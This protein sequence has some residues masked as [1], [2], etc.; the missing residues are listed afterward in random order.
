MEL[1][2]DNTFFYRNGWHLEADGKFLPGVHLVSGKIG[3]GKS[4]FS[5][6]AAG[7]LSPGK[8]SVKRQGIDSVMLSMQFPEYHVTGS[9]L[10]AEIR[11]WGLDPEVVLASSGLSGYAEKDPFRLSRGE[12]KRL[13]LHCILSR[14]WDLLILDEPFS[15]LDCREKKD[16][17]HRIDEIT[18]GIVIVCTH[19][20]R[21]FPHVDVIWEIKS[22][23]LIRNGE[24]PLA[25][26]RWSHAPARIRHL[27]ER[28]IIPENISEDAI[29][30]ASCRIRE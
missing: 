20:Q 22:G 21:F 23:A 10:A 29:L 25:L 1:V 19:E 11:S 27:V 17:C 12:L 7:L 14:Q 4:T 18:G 6:L 2:F 28:G 24:L 8:G 15:A 26:T 16:V 3:A 9:T 5:L 13:H 30:E